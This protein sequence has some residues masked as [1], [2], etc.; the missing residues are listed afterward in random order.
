MAGYGSIGWGAVR[1]YW[2]ATLTD[3]WSRS[4]AAETRCGVSAALGRSRK[5]KNSNASHKANARDG[6]TEGT[7]LTM[8]GFWFKPLLSA[9]NIILAM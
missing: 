8:A 4:E 7:P 1:R 5:Y 3:C 6:V 2:D 9:L